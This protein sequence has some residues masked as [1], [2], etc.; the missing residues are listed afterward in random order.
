[1]SQIVTRSNANLVDQCLR[2]SLRSRRSSWGSTSSFHTFLH[3]SVHK[4]TLQDFK[5]P[6]RCF[7][8][9]SS[10]IPTCP[11]LRK[12][13]HVWLCM[14]DMYCGGALIDTLGY[15]SKN[16]KHLQSTWLRS[17]HLAL[18]SLK[19][20]YRNVKT[21]QNKSK[22]DVEHGPSQRASDSSKF[23]IRSPVR[24]ITCEIYLRLSVLIFI[25]PCA[26]TNQWVFADIEFEVN[27][28]RDRLNELM[29]TIPGPAPSPPAFALVLWTSTSWHSISPYSCSSQLYARPANPIM[30]K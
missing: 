24:M 29:G 1:M 17:E 28:V 11:K 21:C 8:L 15:W 13:E 20:T 4:D 12:L 14:T 22:L 16:C 23:P 19:R 5:N 30:F 27:R 6:A 25:G 7:S 3:V 2:N 26:K 9:H 18:Q 10:S